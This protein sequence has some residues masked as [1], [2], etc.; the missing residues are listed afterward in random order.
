MYLQQQSIDQLKRQYQE[1]VA[2]F[3]DTGVEE[4]GSMVDCRMVGIRYPALT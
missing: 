3:P 4:V 2:C 1:N